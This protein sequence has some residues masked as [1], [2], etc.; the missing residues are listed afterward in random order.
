MYMNWKTK[1]KKGTMTQSVI[2]EMNSN[3]LREFTHEVK[4][5]LVNPLEIENV[6]KKQKWKLGW[7]ACNTGL[8]KKNWNVCLMV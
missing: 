6:S 8:Y 5:D 2:M 1:N 4:S 7:M 3:V